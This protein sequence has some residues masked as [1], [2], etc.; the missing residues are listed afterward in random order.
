MGVALWKHL[1]GNKLLTFINVFSGI[2]MF[3][4]GYNQG[5]M[6]GVNTVSQYMETVGIGSNGVITNT[7]KQ[8]GYRPIDLWN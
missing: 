5:V 3:F 1:S 6:G 2:A 8:G 7:T 4:E